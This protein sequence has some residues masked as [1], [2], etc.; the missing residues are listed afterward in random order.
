MNKY[1]S[2]VLIFASLILSSFTFSQYTSPESVTYDSAYN[3]Y[4]VTNSGGV[5][6]QR[7][8]AGVVTDF[9]PS[10]S[11]SHGIRIYNGNAYACV[12]N[13]IKGFALSN[14]AEVF[15]VQLT[16]ASFLNGMGI[17]ASGIAY[18]SDFTGQKIYKLNLNTE[19]WWIY[20]ATAGGQPNGVYVD[21]P[22]N[23]LLVCYWGSNAA[24]KS[25]NL[26]DSTINTL[27]NTGYNNCDGI[28][29]DKYDNVY[30]S[31]WSPSPAKILRYDINFNFPAI[32][33]N[34]GL[35]NPADIF[36]N[37]NADTLAV[38]NS[39]N[40][41]VTFHDIGN[42][43]GITQLS[44]NVPEKFNLHQNYPNP[45][46]P[47]TKIKFDIPAIGSNNYVAVQLIIYNAMGEAVSKPVDENL[48]SGRY[49]IDFISPGIS[50]GIYFYTLRA[51]EFVQ[52]RKMMLIK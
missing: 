42:I 43:S 35:S 4:L 51:G 16:S 49:E 22:R 11:G 31:S 14:G 40:S 45:F 37:K 28:Y 25:V 21:S 2:I 26:A 9:A 3:R 20:V 29:L 8:S 13:R 1:Y 38:P 19:A 15:N 33:I 23:R 7:S 18:I 30:V 44:G 24:I 27:I 48:A 6:K 17:S 41:T 52:S 32:P 5:I 50:S 34:S 36:I 10:G 12:G 39:G 47:T 46:N